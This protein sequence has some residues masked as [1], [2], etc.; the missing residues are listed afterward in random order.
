MAGVCSDGGS[1]DREHRQDIARS[2]RT[3]QNARRQ[4]RSKCPMNWELAAPLRHSTAAAAG[5]HQRGDRPPVRAQT[6]VPGE[7]Y[8]GLDEE[9]A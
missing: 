5:R 2:S 8:R 7:R 4:R 9:H 1:G 3:G 6:A